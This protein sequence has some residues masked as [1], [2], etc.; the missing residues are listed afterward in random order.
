MF[1]EGLGCFIQSSDCLQAEQPGVDSR[2]HVQ[3][4]LGP[5]HLAAEV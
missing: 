5:I 1:W 2:H 3:T 4:V